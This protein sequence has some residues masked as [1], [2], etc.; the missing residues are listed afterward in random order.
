[1]D[2]TTN[3]TANGNYKIATP[4]GIRHDRWFASIYISGNFGAGTVTLFTSPDNGTTLI[5]ATNSSG[6]A[7]STTT[8]AMTDISLGFARNLQ[9]KITVWATLAGATA[10]NLNV[11]V[12]DN[13]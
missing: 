7:F 4:D 8:N 11:A 1:M 2:Y 12:F 10:P 3:I 6:V 9:G 13:Q 5:P